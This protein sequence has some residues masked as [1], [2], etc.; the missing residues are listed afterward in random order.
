[1]KAGLK[2]A[3]DYDIQSIENTCSSITGVSRERLVN[4]IEQ[5]DAVTNVEVGV[6]MSAIIT[7]QYSQALDTIIKEVL[8]D[9]LNMAKIVYKEG[10]KGVLTLGENLQKI[11]TA[12]PKYY[13]LTDHD[14]HVNDS[15]ELLKDLE[16]IKQITQSLIQG[17]LVEAEVVVDSIDAKSMTEMKFKM[18]ESMKKQKEEMS[19]LSQ[20]KQQ[21]EQLQQQLQQAQQQ[22]QQMQ[23]EKQQLDSQ[24][25]QFE[26]Q[27]AEKDREI[28]WYKAKADKQYKE[29]TIDT[30][31]K[32]LQAEVMEIYDG[33][34]KNT[35]VKNVI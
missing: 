31:E 14:I 29:D 12:I 35:E 19:E 23:Q 8:T 22:M 20:A 11:F 30:K 27:E 16:T 7:K 21:L 17:G 13:T 34:P 6:K 18:K 5:K 15:S 9:W 10:I 26:A 3:F 32:L 33:N 28:E 2:Q 25:M 4:G 24:K 1:M